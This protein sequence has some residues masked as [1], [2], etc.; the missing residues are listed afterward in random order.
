MVRATL[1][2]GLGIA[3]AACQSTE[4]SPASRDTTASEGVILI[5]TAGPMS[6][7][8]SAFGDQMVEGTELAVRD[9]NERGG[10]LGNEVELV[11]GDDQCDPRT[12]VS[13]ANQMAVD[14]VTFVAG[15][16]CS[17]AS[18]PASQVYTETGI[19]QISPASTNPA[20]TANGGDNVFRVVARDEQQGEI[21]G[22]LIADRY[23]TATI[24]VL[25]DGSIYGQYLSQAAMTT[26]AA[27]GIPVEI[28]DS[29]E[30]GL[31]DAGPLVDDL[32][33]QNV[34]VLYVGGYDEDVGLIA[35]ELS[36]R[37]MN[38]QLIAGDALASRSFRRIAGDASDGTLMTFFPDATNL[39][40]AADILWRL[41]LQEPGA[42]G[43]ELYAYA[44]V[45]IWAEAAERA[46]TID[47]E[48]L[49]AELRR[50]TFDTVVGQ[51]SFDENGDIEQPGYAWYEWRGASY[52]PLD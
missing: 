3:L 19:L 33:A 35:R 45:Q 46:G 34:E 20:L 17:A 50:G 25:H 32:N 31:V 24:A 5:G 12:A 28:F 52:R 43:Y 40:E 41:R 1:L 4:T 37:G 11:I 27:R 49:I 13:V 7:R 42:A 14:G 16:F 10:V 21:A 2:L 9:L 39:P 6:G 36:N 38:T 18:I 51:L 47:T 44:A 15:H 26:L 30:Q 48:A 29:F 8:F 22:T 23:P